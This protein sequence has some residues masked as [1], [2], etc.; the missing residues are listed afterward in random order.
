MKTDRIITNF[1]SLY[2][3]V[4]KAPGTFNKCYVMKNA[5]NSETALLIE[6]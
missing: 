5:Y 2:C 1:T 6:H 4:T 3:Q